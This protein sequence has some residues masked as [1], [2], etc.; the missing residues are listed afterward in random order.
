MF[1]I[2]GVE[3][4]EYGVEFA[5]G[6]NIVLL[7]PPANKERYEYNWGDQNGVEYYENEILYKKQQN[8]TLNAII[9]G[10]SKID[11]VEKFRTFISLINVSG[12]FSLQSD[13][14]IDAVQLYYNIGAVTGLGNDWLTFSISVVN[15]WTNPIKLGF[16]TDSAGDFITDFEDKKIMVLA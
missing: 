7:S 3:S 15:N 2:N 11:V 6:T 5:S 10:S 14:V 13:V 16:L 12:G 8:F 1:Y 9:K 4:I